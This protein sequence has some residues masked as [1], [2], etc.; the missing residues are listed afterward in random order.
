[1]DHHSSIVCDDLDYVSPA[2]FERHLTL[3]IC[4]N[5][6]TV[7]CAPVA[8]QILD[9]FSLAGDGIY[10]TLIVSIWEL[11]EALGPLITAPLSEMFGRRLVY[12]IANMLFIVFA[13]CCATST[14][15]HSLVA[16]RFLNGL[17]VA[18]ITLNP[19]KL[20]APYG[21]LKHQ[22]MNHRC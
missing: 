17:V 14:N 19:G 11:G 1:M 3:I 10:A 2:L 8:P 5:I 6:A 9:D 22:V 13:I 4:R 16:F 21:V 18:A 20:P 15:I 7:M 12:N